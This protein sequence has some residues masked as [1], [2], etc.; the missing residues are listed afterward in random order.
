MKV[1][2]NCHYGAFNQG[3]EY[4]LRECFARQLIE[5]GVAKKVPEPIVS[6]EAK[7]RIVKGVVELNKAAAKFKEVFKTFAKKPPTR[8][9]RHALIIKFN[10]LAGEIKELEAGLDIVSQSPETEQWIIE[11]FRLDI[12]LKR[13]QRA[14]VFEMIL[15]NKFIPN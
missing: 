2:F 1:K 13:R 5:D 4:D 3:E 8:D 14:T 7:E 9:Q 10:E 11:T 12:E 15:G 6:E